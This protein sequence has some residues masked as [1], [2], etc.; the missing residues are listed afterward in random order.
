[1]KKGFVLTEVVVSIAIFA[2]ISVILFSVFF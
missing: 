2:T 1:M